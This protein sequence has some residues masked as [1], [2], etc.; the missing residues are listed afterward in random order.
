M[1]NCRTAERITVRELKLKLTRTKINFEE[2][3]THIEATHSPAENK[4]Q[5]W[6]SFVSE[7]SV[8]RPDASE[9]RVTCEADHAD[10]RTRV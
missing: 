7:H 2:S 3:S 10:I 8:G 1:L 4:T 6:Q 5:S 9:A